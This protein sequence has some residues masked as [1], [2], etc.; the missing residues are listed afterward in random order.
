MNESRHSHYSVATLDPVVTTIP[1]PFQ[2]AAPATLDGLGTLLGRIQAGE[3]LMINSRRKNG[4]ILG[5]KFHAEFA[6]PGAAIG[7]ALDLDC[8]WILPLGSLALVPL[9]GFQEQENA[10]KIRLQWMKLIIQN[11]SEDVTA[12][13]RSFNLL[14]RF[15]SYFDAITISRV[16]DE[17]WAKLI[18][19]F[20]KTVQSA[21]RGLNQAA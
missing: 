2:N 20:P 4:L 8:D 10:L 12:M 3:R 21:R 17:V 11:C 1:S 5:K 6:G 16:P 13:E 14:D 15:E 19:V 18:G 7:G 9:S